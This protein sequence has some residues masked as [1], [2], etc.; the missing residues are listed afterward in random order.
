MAVFG[1]ADVGTQY[2]FYGYKTWEVGDSPSLTL[3][4]PM[5]TITAGG[6]YTYGMLH[7]R[8]YWYGTYDMFRARRAG[9]AAF[10]HGYVGC[11]ILS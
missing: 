8:E 5:N 4:L 11:E 7:S 2:H 3:A 10:D 6:N 1:A 9:C